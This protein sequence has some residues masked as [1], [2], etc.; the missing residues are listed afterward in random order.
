MISLNNFENIAEDIKATLK[1]NMDELCKK[2]KIGMV[3][4][5]I[6]SCPV[7]ERKRILSD[8]VKPVGVG[9][10]VATSLTLGI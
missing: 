5:A 3:V 10:L 4:F 7:E 6:P 2:H 8:I 9:G 1:K